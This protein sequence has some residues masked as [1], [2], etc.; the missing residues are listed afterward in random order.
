MKR[1]NYFTILAAATGALVTSGLWHSSLLA[2][3]LFKN[4]V[5]A[6]VLAHFAVRFRICDWKGGVQLG[7]GMWIGFQVMLLIGTVLHERMLWP[8][9]VIHA[10]DAFAKT[11]PMNIIFGA[12]LR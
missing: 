8:L 7:L 9:Y 11:L 4:I 2:S 1:I 3:G 6:F 10:G 5:V 12:C